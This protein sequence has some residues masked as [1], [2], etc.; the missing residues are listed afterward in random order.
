MRGGRQAD[1][2]LVTALAQIQILGSF[3]AWSR[4]LSPLIL[5][6]TL[7]A[8]LVLVAARLRPVRALRLW[9]PVAV[10]V[11]TLALL[12]APTVWSVDTT[13]TVGSSIPTAGPSA[14]GGTA[15]VV[16]SRP[17]RG[18]A[19]PAARHRQVRDPWAAASAAAIRAAA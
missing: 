18:M 8:C 6:P 4:W 7:I 16:D 2:L 17:G 1:A 9:T 13:M 14:Q 5:V 11:G 12:L 10:A 19:T 15:L 3:P